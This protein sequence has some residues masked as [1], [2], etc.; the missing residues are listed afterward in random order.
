MSNLYLQ[1]MQPWP[2]LAGYAR[3][4][5]LPQSGLRIFT[6]DTARE[7][8]GPQAP[9]LLVHGLGDEAD[10]WRHVVEPL[11]QQRRVIALDLPGFG[12]SDK[13]RRAYSLTFFRDTII[14]L[15]DALAIPQVSLV[16]HSLGGIIAHTVALVQP[17][18]LR[19]LTLID[20]CLSPH[21]QKM[22]LE[23]VFRLLPFVGERYYNGLRGR[24]KAAYASL[25]A[26]YTDIIRL[27]EADRQFLFQRVNE[28]VWSDRQRDA[29]FSVLRQ[30]PAW[31]MR[32]QRS[33]RAGLGTLTVPTVVVW[34]Q[35][36][37]IIP[38]RAGQALVDIQASAHLVT[39]TG[40]GHMPHQEQPAAFLQAIAT[41]G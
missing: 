10:T 40:S 20:G 14:E 3:T 7:R 22:R 23:M 39:I 21:P 37:Q 19:D 5:M 25:A 17:Q 35:D 16:G 34:G 28:R 41:V 33:L 26:Y 15:L 9:V 1:P 6:F 30:M 4:V 18:R 36:D 38:V 13:P 24:P 32:H 27:P 12:R 31:M 2:A 29:Y 8:V 11:A